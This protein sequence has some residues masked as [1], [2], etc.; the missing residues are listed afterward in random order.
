MD[1]INKLLLVFSETYP[2]LKNVTIETEAYT[3]IFVAMCLVD[4]V[5]EY[6]SVKK[7]TYT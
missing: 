3:N 5:G 6:I 7:R 2:L 4:R 1:K